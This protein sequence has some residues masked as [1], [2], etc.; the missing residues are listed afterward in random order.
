MDQK[1]IEEVGLEALSSLHKTQR[2]I[3][4]CYFDPVDEVLKEFNDDIK[5]PIYPNEKS[6]RRFY[7][8]KDNTEINYN[9]V[10][11]TAS[12]NTSEYS[13]K[14]VLDQSVENVQNNNQLLEFFS[15]HPNGII[16]FYFYIESNT[17]S[18]LDAEISIELEVL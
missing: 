13:I 9:T 4:I 17:T 3:G 6:Y 5:I 18:Y 2:G 7:I 1:Y 11:I 15:N 8:V 12:T 10:S 16:P 14:T